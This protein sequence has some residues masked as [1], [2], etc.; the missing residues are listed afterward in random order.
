MAYI[1]TIFTT[2]RF[3]PTAIG[4]VEM[5]GSLGLFEG[6]FN[7]FTL[8]KLTKIIMHKHVLNT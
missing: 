6:A 5:S 1:E 8:S 2:D 3:Y 4:A 7:I